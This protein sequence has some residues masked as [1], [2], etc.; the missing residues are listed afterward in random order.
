MFI[1]QDG[2]LYFSNWD[3]RYLCI[4]QTEAEARRLDHIQLTNST[5][6]FN[7]TFFIY[8]VRAIYACGVLYLSQIILVGY[9]HSDD[10]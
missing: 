2:P 3:E 4:F 9:I 7:I 10:T 6:W 8:S 1:L 5:T